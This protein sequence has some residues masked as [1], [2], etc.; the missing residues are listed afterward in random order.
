MVVLLANEPRAY[1]E[2]LAGALQIMRPLAEV[3]VADPESLDREVR[4]LAPS[5]VV[6]SRLT[7]AVKA[8]VPAWVELYP[9]DGP[10]SAETSVGGE[11]ATVEIMNLEALLSLFDRAVIG[12]R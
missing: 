11:H 6:C 4:R 1:R 3:V 9:G 8:S 2:A 10:S 7:A 12:R 5:F